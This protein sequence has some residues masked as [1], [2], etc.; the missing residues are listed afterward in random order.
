MSSEMD[1]DPNRVL[2]LLLVVLEEELADAVI[3]AVV[4]VKPIPI[5]G[6]QKAET[7][8]AHK[9]ARERTKV[10]ILSIGLD[11]LFVYFFP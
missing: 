6:W 5:P 3:V 9:N 2:L 10:F 8:A 1:D 11:F 7:S 4:K